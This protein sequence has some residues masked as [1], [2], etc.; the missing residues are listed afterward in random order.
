M[1]TGRA[2]T[3][4]ER[5][6]TRTHFPTTHPGNGVLKIRDA[7][8]A[9]ALT[10]LFV[11][12]DL[13]LS[14]T[15]PWWGVTFVFTRYSVFDTNADFQWPVEL[16]IAYHGLGASG[17]TGL[18]VTA[19][20]ILCSLL[21]AAAV[22]LVIYRR[23]TRGNTTRPEDQFVGTA[24][25]AAAV[26]FLGSRLLVTVGGYLEWIS[27]PVGALYVAFVGGVFYFDLFRLGTD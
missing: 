1:N 21:A 7:K 19:V 10:V 22:G 3:D 24:L 15:E 23:L 14:R 18:V 12:W 26:V 11:P 4:A 9:F 13:L 5:V 25:M 8:V 20:W 17:T 6:R 2:R 27:V 16:L